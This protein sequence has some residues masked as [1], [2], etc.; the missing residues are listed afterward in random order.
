M[1]L[2][3][4]FFSCFARHSQEEG[5]TRLWRGN[6]TNVVRVVPYSATQ[7]ASYDF[8]KT[9]VYR[10]PKE[11]STQRPFG[12]AHRLSAGALAGQPHIS[13]DLLGTHSHTLL[14][15]FSSLCSAIAATTITHPLD[16]IR[17]RLNVERELKGERKS[18]LRSFF[19]SVHFSFCSLQGGVDALQSILKDGGAR[20]LFKGYVPTLLSVSP[21]IAINFACFDT[22][23]SL[24]YPELK[25][26]KPDL[27]PSS[28]SSSSSS[29]SRARSS[30]P[31]RE[32]KGSPQNAAVILGLGAAAGL[33]AQ[34]VCYPLDTVRRRMQMKGQ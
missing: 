32:R 22:L 25:R 20:A 34:T 8:F 13:F 11:G 1:N 19:L 7:F 24:V 16:V 26:Q 33:F 18:A 15:S 4:N 17:L 27:L 10:P 29:G 14:I 3:P 5:L 31:P 2:L 23:K 6:V 21:F 9:L 30:S 28:S 12:T